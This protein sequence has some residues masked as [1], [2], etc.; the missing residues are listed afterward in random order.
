MLYQLSY[1]RG[2]ASVAAVESPVQAL[3]EHPPGADHE[4][5]GRHASPRSCSSATRSQRDHAGR[6]PD[7]LVPRRAPVRGYSSLN[8]RRAQRRDDGRTAARVD[9]AR[10]RRRREGHPRRGRELR[11]DQEAVRL[12]RESS[13]R[14]RTG[15]AYRDMLFTTEGAEEYISGVILYDETIRQRR[16]R[17]AVPAAARASRDHPRDQ[18]RPRARS[19]S[20]STDGARRSPRASTACAGG[21]RSTAGSARASRSG[22]R[23]TRS[24]AASRPSTASGRMRTRWRATRRC[25]RRPGSC[26]S[27]SPR[28]CR[29]ATHTIEQSAK[30]TGR[31]LQAVYTEL[32]DQR[33]DLRRHAAQAEHGAVGLRRDGSRRRATR[34]PSGRSRSST[35]TFRPR[36]PGSSSSPAARPTRTR[37]RT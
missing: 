21:S 15:S 19:R 10:A 23:P 5:A 37:R 29:T 6:L 31:V 32:H 26:R 17:D 16:R 28:C 20:R 36:C 22:A 24:A 14:R 12:D 11:H 33:V 13:R 4:K 1:A 9:R 25:A 18:G 2:A 34:S 27:S 7:D 3:A 8:G 30:A 35:S